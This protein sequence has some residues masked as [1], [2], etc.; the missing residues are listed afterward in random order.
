MLYLRFQH[1]K[2]MTRNIGSFILSIFFLAFLVAPTILQMVDDSID[3]SVFYAAGAEEEES[4]SE[5]TKTFEV[6][7]DISNVNDVGFSLAKSIKKQG[8]CFKKYPKPHLNLFSPPPEF[9]LF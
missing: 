8:Y 4:N 3:V 2:Q 1:S 9:Q 5:K 6:L 7:L